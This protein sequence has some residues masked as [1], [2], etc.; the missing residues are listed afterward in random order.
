M[1]YILLFLLSVQATNL[2]YKCKHYLPVAFAEK[3]EIGYYMGKC[4]KFINM[5]EKTGEVEHF[6][7]V[8]CRVD[9]KMCGKEGKLY[10]YN[11]KY[12]NNMNNI[13]HYE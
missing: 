8:K 13:N 4:N 11:K 10:E 12:S 9:E 5:N 2:C 6:Y 1:Y 3:Y 7:A